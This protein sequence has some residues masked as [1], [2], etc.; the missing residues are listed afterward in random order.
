[1]TNQTDFAL[2]RNDSS[3]GS[4]RKKGIY[5]DKSDMVGELAAIEQFFFL[6]KPKG[7]GKSTLISTLESLFARGLEE[8]KGL[9]IEG[10]W[11]DKTYPVIRPDLSNLDDSSGPDGFRRSLCEAL[12]DA[13]ADVLPDA[14]ARLTEHLL[15]RPSVATAMHL[16]FKGITFENPVVLLI[17]DYDLPTEKARSDPERY[18]YV[19]SIMRSFYASVD[20]YKDSCRFILVTGAR[21]NVPM[22]S[23][24]L[25]W[26][27]CYS[28]I[29]DFDSLNSLTG[30]TAEEIP[31]AFPTEIRNAAVVLSS[32]EDDILSSIVKN[33]SV[34][35][36]SFNPLEPVCNTQAVLDFLAHPQI[37]FPSRQV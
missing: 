6:A 34:R 18:A 28:D 10:T 30:L 26:F 31:G 25:S 5:I 17:D 2:Y 24:E 4:L 8:F 33:C 22:T 14:A 7:F 11:D 12:R 36:F 35:E 9:K 29:S 1:M 21:K 3:F 16:I 32:T 19:T 15:T 13:V 23:N 37:G 20:V 27:D